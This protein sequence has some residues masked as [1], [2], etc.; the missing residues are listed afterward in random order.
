L[1][2]T[3]PRLEAFLRHEGLRLDPHLE[4]SCGIFADGALIAS[5]SCYGSTIRCLA[6]SDRYRGLGLLNQIVGHLLEWQ[7]GRG[8]LHVFVCTKPET[9]DLL[10]RLGFSEIARTA[11]GVVFLENRADGFARYL[12]AL[13]AQRQPVPRVGAVVLHANPFTLGHQFLVEQACAEN[14]WVHLFLL[15]ET[16][17][18][19]PFPVR[20]ELVR[21]GTA[22]LRNLTLHDGGPYIISRDTFPSYFLAD[23]IQVA[24]AH[25]QLDLTLFLRIAHALGIQCRYVGQEPNSAVTALYNRTMQ[26]LLPAAGIRCRVLERRC[27]QGSPISASAVRRALGEGRPEDIRPWVPETTYRYFTS[28]AAASVL[29]RLQQTVK[30]QRP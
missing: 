23:D 3:D 15:S 29:V 20:K 30:E 8:R 16:E 21:Q 12:Q 25:C 7:Q 18:P 28:A 27:W 13:S 10:A 11:Q 5:G 6:V 4:Y 14:D 22:H 26:T 1:D 9:A 17:G 24:A 2:P 19:I